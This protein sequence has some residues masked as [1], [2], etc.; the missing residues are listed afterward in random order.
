MSA[1]RGAHAGVGPIEQFMTEDHVSIDRLLACSEQSDGSIDAE[2][3]EQFRGGL[4]RHIAMEEKVLLPYARS[5]RGGEPLAMA[6]ALRADHG[7]IAKLLTSRPSPALLSEVRALLGRHNA[8]EEGAQGLYAACDA[9]AGEDA[10]AVVQR[11]REQPPVPLAKY[12]E[13]PLHRRH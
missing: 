5:R 3:Y 11:L 7:G 8:L 4:L 12:Y 13:G 1:T 6:A 2:H 10:P 9:L